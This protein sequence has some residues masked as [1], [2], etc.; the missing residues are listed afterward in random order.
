MADDKSRSSVGA[1]VN[2]MGRMS[3]EDGT[4]D[5]TSDSLQS[6]D[7]VDGANA[8]IVT[9]VSDSVFENEQCKVRRRVTRQRILLKLSST[10]GNVLMSCIYYLQELI[11]IKDKITGLQYNLYLYN[12]MFVHTQLKLKGGVKHSNNHSPNMITYHLQY[13]SPLYDGRNATVIL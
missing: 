7:S 3:M 4:S 11:R 1:V 9:K 12:I 13:I 10:N 5:G 8:L 6:R 2:K